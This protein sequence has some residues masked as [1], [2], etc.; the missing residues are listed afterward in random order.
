VVLVV[1]LGMW[2]KPTSF[3]LAFKGRD[4]SNSSEGIYPGRVAALIKLM[5]RLMQLKSFK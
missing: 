3:L 5:G 1:T 2:R 4:R